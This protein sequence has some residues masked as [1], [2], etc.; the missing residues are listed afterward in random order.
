MRYFTLKTMVKEVAI[1]KLLDLFD[2]GP[3]YKKI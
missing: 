3:S 1:T 2:I